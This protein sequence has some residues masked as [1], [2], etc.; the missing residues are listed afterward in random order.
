MNGAAIQLEAARHRIQELEGLCRQQQEEIVR[1]KE[2][3]AVLNE[4]N[5]SAGTIQTIH[6]L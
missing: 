6:D 1:L 2:R 4:P 5:D 3:L